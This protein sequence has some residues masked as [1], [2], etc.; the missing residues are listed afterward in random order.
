LF[1]EKEVTSFD[2]LVKAVRVLDEDSG[3]RLVGKEGGRLRLV[4]ATRFGEK[5][6]VMT[7]AVVGK[8]GMPGRR[9]AAA[10]FDSVDAVAAELRRTSPGRIRAYVY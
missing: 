9:L 5:Y 6:T 4:F 8:T 3:I 7:Y 1:Y 2:D 10:E